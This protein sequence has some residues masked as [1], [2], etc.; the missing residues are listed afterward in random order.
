MSNPI[1]RGSDQ[2]LMQPR[3]PFVAH[4]YEVI[5]AGSR[6]LH[7]RLRRRSRRDF[8]AEIDPAVSGQTPRLT[9]QC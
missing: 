9:L 2:I 4:H 8:G 6:I 5:A 7:D 3:V 1:G